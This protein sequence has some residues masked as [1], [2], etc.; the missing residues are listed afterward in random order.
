M[1]G[2]DVLAGS[3]SSDVTGAANDLLRNACTQT[4]PASPAIEVPAGWLP[5][6]WNSSR[7]RLD[8]ARCSQPWNAGSVL[9]SAGQSYLGP[10]LA[11][12]GRPS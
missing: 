11:D 2:V 6:T 5:A 12:M 10:S 4:K 8:G 9:S 3:I 7:R 1:G